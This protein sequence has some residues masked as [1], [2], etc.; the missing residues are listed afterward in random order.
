[1]KTFIVECWQSVM[2]NRYNPLRELDL[3]SQHYT[4]QVLGWMWSMLFSL[5][6][7]SIFHFAFVWMA[8]LLVIGGVC[9]TVAIFHE[10]EQQRLSRVEQIEH[11]S[12]A[13]KCVWQLDR[14]A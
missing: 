9:L 10:A 4:M 12:Q 3:A 11:L 6:F 5:A 1:M 14:E 13:S 8:H 2:D 7:L